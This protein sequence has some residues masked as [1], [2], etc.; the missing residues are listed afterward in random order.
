SPPPPT[1]RKDLLPLPQPTPVP[2]TPPP[3][4]IRP[5]PPGRPPIITR[6]G[7][8][9]A[10]PVASTRIPPP[11]PVAVP[12]LDAAHGV[13]RVDLAQLD[14]GEDHPGEPAEDLVDVLAREG[15]RL[16]DHGDADRAGPAARLGAADLPAVGRH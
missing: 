2:P 9:H 16:H 12:V 15:A 8:L 5:P 10:R 11:G 4:P 7:A 13:V 1:Q 6:H 3:V 14:L